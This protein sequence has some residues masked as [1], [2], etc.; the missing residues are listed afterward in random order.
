MAADGLQYVKEISSRLED[1][2]QDERAD[3][4]ESRGYDA[5][6]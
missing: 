2:A 4:A 3:Y 6:D 1:A 5:A